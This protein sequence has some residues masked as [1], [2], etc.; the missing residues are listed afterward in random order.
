MP[1]VTGAVNVTGVPEVLVVNSALPVRTLDDLVKFAKATPGGLAFG[2]AG[3][4]TAQHLNG[5][6]LKIKLGIEMTHVPYRGIAPALNDAAGGHISLMFTDIPISMLLMDA[7]K[8]RPIGVTT[9]ERVGALPKVPALAEIGL[10][11]FDESAWFMMLAPAKTPRD[12]AEKLAAEMRL[13]VHDPR[14]VRN[15]SASGC[16]WWTCPGLQSC[17]RSY[18][19]KSCVRARSSAVSASPV[20]NRRRNEDELLSAKESSMAA[21]VNRQ[22]VLKSRPEGT[23]GLDNFALAQTAIPEPGD[24]EVLM[25]TLYLSLDPY[26]RGR[27]SAAK[28]YAKPA[29]V[30]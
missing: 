27:M 16:C 17:R 24:G 1:A 12:I 2:S 11:G 13:A 9:A 19:R 28:S 5:E 6:L 22:I 26:M 14:S 4:G 3:V 8:L 30:G 23:P 20:S 7:G 18:R 21:S 10:T 25:R 15:S 29:E